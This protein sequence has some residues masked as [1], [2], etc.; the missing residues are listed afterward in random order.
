[1][2]KAAFSEHEKSVR[3]ELSES[4][5][6]ISAAIRAHEQGMSAGHA[7]EPPE[8]DAYG[9]ADMADHHDGVR[10]AVRQPERGVVV[11]GELDSVKSGRNRPAE[12]S[13]VE[14][15]REDLGRDVPEDSNGR[16]LVLPKG[17]A[18]DRTQ[19][20]TVGNGRSKQNALRLVK[21]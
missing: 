18:V 1:M 3:A 15:E 14:A 12:R 13:A 5:K 16:F 7:V 20:W 6:R 19:S 2:L 4:G 11:S 8:R 10:T 9:R 17:T 21:E